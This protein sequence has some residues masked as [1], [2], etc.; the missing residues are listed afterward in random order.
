MNTASD[1]KDLNIAANEYVAFDA[2][3]LR[4]FITS[5]LNVNGNFTDQNYEGSNITAINNII[6]YAFHVL[7]YYQN[8]TATESLFSEAQ[9]YENMNRIVKTLNYFPIG[10]QTSTLSFDVSATA[11]LPV[12]TYTIPRY[13]FIRAGNISYSFNEDITFTKTVSGVQ[14]LSDVA[15]QYLLYQGSYIEYPLYTARGEANEIVYLIPGTNVVVDHFNIDVYVLNTG[16]NGTNNATWSKW[17][18]T[19]SLYLQNATDKTYELRLNSNKNYEIKFGDSING[20]QLNVN[21]VVAIYY[22]QTAGTDG[23][24]GVNAIN[25]KNAALYTTAQF[26][27]IQPNVTSSDLNLLN[28]VNILNLNFSNSNIST[29]FTD[30]ESVDSMRNNAPASFRTQYRIVT[31]SDYVSYIKNNFANIINDVAVLNNNDYVNKHLQYLYNIGLTNPGTDYRV[32]YNQMAFAD[33]C[34]FNNVYVYV[35]PKAT[36]LLTNNYINYLTPAQKQ[37]IISTVSGLKTL[38]SEV[39]VMDPVYL[40]VTVGVGINNTVSTSDIATSKLIVT[41]QR[42]A[43]TPISVIQSNIQAI[44]KNYFNPSNITLGYTV[45]VPD[46]TGDILALPDVQSVQTVNGTETVNGVSLVVYNPSYPNNDI[47]FTSKT[48]TVLPFQTV[49]LVDIND[50]LSR[51][52]VQQSVSQSASIV[53]F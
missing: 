30:I 27:E 20:A 18:K 6:A 19:E 23:Q 26:T 41:L 22:L 32:L 40:A 25:G 51:V 35:L 46:I 47:S 43:Q 3:S 4:S 16:T 49:Y 38:T 15:N 42:G 34:N 24:V 39:V 33:A 7:L 31:T 50:I 8:Q 13:T 48:F 12:G 37:L 1:N 14:E 29:T 17:T 28:D 44:F 21:D 52:V 11:N 10:A 53:N 5:R 45:N 36:A 9:L 2:L